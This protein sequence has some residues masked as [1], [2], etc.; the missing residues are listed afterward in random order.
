MGFDPVDGLL[1][2]A[3]GLYVACDDATG[4]PKFIDP[5][6]EADGVTLGLGH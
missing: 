1:Q 6:F 4:L 5:L 2:R 3:G